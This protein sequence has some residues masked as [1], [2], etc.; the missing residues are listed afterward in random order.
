VIDVDVRKLY[1]R[2]R[3]G[4][5]ETE[6]HYAAVEGSRLL[7]VETVPYT[8]VDDAR[9]SMLDLGPDVGVAGYIGDVHAA[10][11]H[12][13]RP[14]PEPV[15][16]P[17]EMR[18]L[19]GREIRRTTL[20]HVRATVKPVFVKP[21]MHK[22][23][24]GFV[25]LPNGESRMRLVQY[26]DDTEVW[27]SEVVDFASEHRAF[28]LR[29][30]LLDVRR[31]KGDWSL[32]PDR[33]VIEEATWSSAPAACC[34]DFGVT[35]D[36]RTLLVEANDGFAFGS[37]GLATKSYVR[38]IAARWLELASQPELPSRFT[39]WKITVKGSTVL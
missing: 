23:F 7:G 35:R 34:V 17:D 5:P 32:A 4:V 22:L 36:G 29:G 19:L 39:S 25:H 15:D 30:E 2:Y 10:L 18:H 9:E 16:Y 20:Y 6:M 33:R 12:I 26:P 31:Y 38:M 21:V 11:D 37:Y 28:V 8:W 3:E 24:T 13:N 14:V 27:A 1:V